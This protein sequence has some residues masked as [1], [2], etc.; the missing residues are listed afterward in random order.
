ME[1]SRGAFS[2]DVHNVFADD[3]LVVALVTVKAQ[4]NEVSTSFPHVHVWRMKNGKGDGVP[5]VSGRRVARGPALVLN[6]S[7]RR[8]TTNHRDPR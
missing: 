5:R 4:R 6:C 8:S 2:I 7:V 3:D 1:L